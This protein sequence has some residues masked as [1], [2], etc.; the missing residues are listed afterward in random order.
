VKLVRYGAPGWEKPGLID[1]D[2]RIRSLEG[3]I[4]DV[5]GGALAP[6]AME[7]LAN[8][9]M[10]SLPL[11]EDGARL[12]PCVGG[13]GKIV[14]VGLNYSDHAKEAGMAIPE[15]P[16]L[17]LK[18]NS[19]LSGPYD[20]IEIPKNSRETD[21]EV[22]LGIVIGT[23]AKY[24]DESQSLKHVA[25]YFLAN[26]VSEREFQQRRSGQWD[27]GKGC[28]TFCPIGPWLVTPDEIADPQNLDLWL[29]VN[30][31]R[32]QA[33]TTA[34]MIFKI[35]FLI[36]YISHFMTLHPGDLIITGT[37]PGVGQGLKPPRFLQKGDVVELGGAGL[38]T[39][40]QAVR[41]YR[42]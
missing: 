26:D 41:A 42:G 4:S 27:K 5:S 16:I 33:G 19:S 8:L 1:A 17:F 15:E 13:V 14:A 6:E 29:E 35:P 24:V 22:E 2:G 25:G 7:R 20:D 39:Q 37:P 23:R 30:G 38:G 9:D 32:H 12:G 36:S 10:E 31:E 34:T 18:A 28:D 3:E 21:W 11:V 40:R